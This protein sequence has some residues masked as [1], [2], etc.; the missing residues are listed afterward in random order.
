MPS[1]KKV[2]EKRK[3]AKDKGRALGA[4]A[5]RRSFII[6]TTLFYY[7]QQTGGNAVMAEII[8]QDKFDEKV[9]KADKPVLVDF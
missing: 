8:M 1:W 5:R 9:L 6:I 3:A 7:S 4:A 2:L